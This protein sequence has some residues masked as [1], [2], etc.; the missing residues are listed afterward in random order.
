[1]KVPNVVSSRTRAL[2]ALLAGTCALAFASAC[3]GP[4]EPAWSPDHASLVFTSNRSG[5]AEIYVIAAGAT[6]WTN[7]TKSP[8][9]ENWPAWSPDGRRI[10]FCQGRGHEAARDRV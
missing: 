2:R 4:A 3:A 1:M 10:A 8:A 6:E 9:T 7:L 5:N